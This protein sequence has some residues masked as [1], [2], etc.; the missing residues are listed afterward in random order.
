MIQTVVVVF[1]KLNES[2]FRLFQFLPLFLSIL[3]R[4]K[5]KQNMGFSV[6]PPLDRTTQQHTRKTSSSKAISVFAGSR[7]PRAMPIARLRGPNSES[8][9]LEPAA[10][11]LTAWSASAPPPELSMSASLASGAVAASAVAD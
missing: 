3:F 9:T 6:S 7:N 1:Q 5:R 4:L 10:G 8:V 2:I 11:V